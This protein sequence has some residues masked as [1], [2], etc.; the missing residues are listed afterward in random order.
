MPVTLTWPLAPI[1]SALPSMSPGRSLSFL[2]AGLMS[3]LREDG[4]SSD[5][6]RVS[7]E[8]NV[9]Q[10]LKDGIL[11]M[12]GERVMG[13]PI[14]TIART[15]LFE[16]SNSVADLLVPSVKDF[17]TNL[18]P[19][20]ILQNVSVKPLPT[21]RSDMVGFKVQVIYVIRATTTRANLVFPFYLTSDEQT[22]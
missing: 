7:D 3:P 12:I 21:N 10:C 18:E 14:G 1:V 8:A 19:R 22:Q 5:F 20:V 17:I 15:I 11:T 2:G 16:E 9:A 13:E 4:T 6:Q